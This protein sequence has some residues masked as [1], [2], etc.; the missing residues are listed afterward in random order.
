MEQKSKNVDSKE[1]NSCRDKNIMASEDPPPSTSRPEKSLW[2]H[3]PSSEAIQYAVSHQKLFLV[4]ISSPGTTSEWERAWA[5]GDISTLLLEHAVCLKLEQGTNDAA[6]F[7]QLVGTDAK[8]EGVWIVFAGQ[9]LDKFDSPIALEE[10]LLRIQDA[11]DKAGTLAQAGP[12]P[13]PQA[14]DSRSENI[15]AQLAERRARLEAA[16]R[17]NGRH[18]VLI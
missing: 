1:K 13:Q 6:M 12:L 11:V 10:M 9:L 16:K 4:F 8:A 15:K 7:L 3:G 14:T 2:H 5:N 17:H 18:S